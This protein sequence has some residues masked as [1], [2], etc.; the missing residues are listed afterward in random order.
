MAVI[1]FVYG[2][3]Y[4]V[5]TDGCRALTALASRLKTGGTHGRIEEIQW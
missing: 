4:P 3:P 2:I 1:T 5:D